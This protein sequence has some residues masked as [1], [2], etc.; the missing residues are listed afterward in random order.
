MNEKLS[1]GSESSFCLFCTTIVNPLNSTDWTTDNSCYLKTISKV[2]FLNG[3]QSLSSV[4][5]DKYY[6]NL[7]GEYCETPMYFEGN[8]KDINS[9]IFI[10][11]STL[12]GKYNLTIDYYHLVF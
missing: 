3:F 10:D 6:F 8:H 4:G 9:T 11:E 12:G 1:F 2:S 5:M 7:N